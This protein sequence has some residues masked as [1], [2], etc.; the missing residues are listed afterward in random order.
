MLRAYVLLKHQESGCVSGG[1]GANDSPVWEVNVLSLDSETTINI[2]K[3]KFTGK[4]SATTS[5]TRATPMP[6]KSLISATPE[7]KVP[8]KESIK[9]VCLG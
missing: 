5:T 2:S 1:I 8:L 4:F 3:D 6:A 9:E 7:S